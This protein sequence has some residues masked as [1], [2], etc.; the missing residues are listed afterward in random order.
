MTENKTGVLVVGQQEKHCLENMMSNFT[1]MFTRVKRKLLL[2]IV[3]G[4]TLSLN[5]MTIWII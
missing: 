5:L 2:F 4:A 3:P 1:K